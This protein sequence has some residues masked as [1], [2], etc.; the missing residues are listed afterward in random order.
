MQR[1]P[2]LWTTERKADV[3]DM[4]NDKGLSATDIAVSIAE[5]TGQRVTRNM[6]ISVVKRMR[7]AGVHMAAR[8]ASLTAGRPRTRP[9]RPAKPREAQAA[10][11]AVVVPV[12]PE[13][14]PTASTF[15]PEP[16]SLV[17]RD[18][19]SQCGFII[20][21]ATIPAICCGAPIS[22][23]DPQSESYCAVHHKMTHDVVQVPP[24][25]FFSFGRRAA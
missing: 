23:K 12:R 10:K 21:D 6:V 22:R 13:A 16:V 5:E 20:D 19:L 24:G 17:E 25:K 1:N 9:E 18:M 2:E 14:P 4:W 11:P 3:A 8:Q 15:N 7:H